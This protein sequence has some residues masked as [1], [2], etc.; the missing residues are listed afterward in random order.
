M[1]GASG[2]KGTKR[3]R[4]ESDDSNDGTT[5]IHL[6]VTTGEGVT[7]KLQLPPTATVLIVKQEVESELGIR[8]REAIVFSGNTAHTEKLQDDV[9]LDSLLVGEEAKLELLLLVEQADAQQV[10]PELAVEPSTILGDGTVGDGDTRLNWPSDAAFRGAHSDWLVIVEMDGHRI[11]ISNIRTGALVCK[12][13]EYGEGDTQLKCPSG[14]AVTSDSS[15]VTIADFVNHRVQVLRLV[16]GADGISAHLEFFRSLG[17]GQGSADGKLQSPFGVAFLQSNGG[18]RETVLVT[19]LGNH[20]V[21]QFALDGTF[22]GIFAGTGEMGSGD[23]EFSCPRGIT[24]LGSSGEVAVANRNNHRVQIFDSAGNYKRQFGTKGEEDGQLF[25]P[26]GLASDAH[27][28]L[29]VMDLTNRLQVFDHEGKHLCTRSDLGLQGRCCGLQTAGSQCL[30]C[31]GPVETADGV[32]SLSA[33]G[34]A[35]QSRPDRRLT[36]RLL[37]QP[38]AEISDS[39]KGIAWSAGGEIAVTDGEVHSVQVWSPA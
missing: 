5:N 28:N 37:C 9:T 16:V 2:N 35:D 38:C 15:F 25:Y 19:E 27:G 14:V 24:V 32:F 17:S 7:V 10:V 23:G 21:S 1:E 36:H 34:W 4:E 26:S 39:D 22:V 29:I 20:Q 12:F 33:G 6:E 8:P 30:G 13:G 31:G 3:T 11:K 18:Q